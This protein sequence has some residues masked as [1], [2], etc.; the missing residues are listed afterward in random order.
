MAFAAEREA[1]GASLRPSSVVDGVYDNIYHRLMSLEIAPGARIPIDVLAREIG[2]S[3]TPIREALSR[4]EREGLVRKE[5]L[6]G[7]SAAPQWTRKQ[8]EDLD[9]QDRR[10]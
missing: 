2:V 8:F 10:K 4:L 1:R 9:S 6:V 7:Y 5:H 3:Q